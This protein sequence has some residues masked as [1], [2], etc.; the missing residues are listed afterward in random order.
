MASGIFDAIA[1]GDKERVRELVAADPSVVHERDDQGTSAILHA[2]YRGK[3][4]LVE[5]MLEAE[6]E[7]DVFEAAALGNVDRLRALV[8]ADP[9]LSNEHAPDGFHALGLAA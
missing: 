9:T 7:L 5:A 3:H 6:P 8:H 4:D 2:R 1:A